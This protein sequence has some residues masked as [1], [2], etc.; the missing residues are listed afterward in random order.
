VFE[1]LKSELQD[2]MTKALEVLHLELS[3]LRTGKPTPALIE[4]IQV[5][6]YDSRMPINQ[7]GTISVLGTMLVVNPWDKK[8]TKDIEKAIAAAN[9]GVNPYSDSDMVKIPI[10][11]LSEERRKDL[12]KGVFKYAEQS[13][14][15]LRN[16][17]RDA[18]DR[19]K[20][21]EKERQISEDELHRLTAEVQKITNEYTE[22]V[23]SI[24]HN[25]EQDIMSF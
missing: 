14:V 16:I 6:A 23:D 1:N 12:V 24:A 22:K 19:I 2:K 3:S 20:H 18:M 17:R 11:P 10:P 15:G 9:L 4:F 7:L 13:K 5:E 8:V 21:A 25:K